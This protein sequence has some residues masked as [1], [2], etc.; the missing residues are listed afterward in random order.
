MLSG[1]TITCFAASYAIA[2]VLEATRMFFRAPVRL[3]VIVGFTTAGLFA[4]SVYLWNLAR[5]EAQ[6]NVLF[7]S[8]YDW[9]LLAAWTLSAVYLFLTVR[10]PRT[11]LGVFL[12][13]VTLLLIGMAYLA[14]ESPPF[15]RGQTLMV[16]GAAHGAALLLGVV[17]VTLGFVAGLMY[18]AQSYRLRHKLPPRPGFRLPSLEALQ[19]VNRQALV[20]SWIFIVAGLGAGAILN[21]VK[22]SLPGEGALP[23]SDRAIVMSG[24]LLL[25]VVAAAIFEVA[26]KPARQGQKVAYLTI[27]SFVLMGLTLLI[28]LFGESRHARSSAGRPASAAHYVHSSERGAS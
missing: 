17:V 21:L 28:V 9:C 14:R 24:V 7:A 16:W 3:A 5:Q 27:F 18:L 22:H 11:P 19:T 8:W 1:I 10:N 15:P 4:Q 6:G 13:P 12:L 23:W 2:L 25:W 26:Y 20:C